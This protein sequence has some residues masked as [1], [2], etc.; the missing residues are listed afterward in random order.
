MTAKLKLELGSKANGVFSNVRALECPPPALPS[1][2][3]RNERVKMGGSELPGMPDDNSAAAAFFD[4]QLRGVYDK[5]KYGNEDTS[6]NH[7]R[8]KLPQM[9]EEIIIKFTEEIGRVLAR[10]SGTLA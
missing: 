2:I 3:T 9:S 8:V 7:V 10:R 6:R 1:A 5:M 4:P